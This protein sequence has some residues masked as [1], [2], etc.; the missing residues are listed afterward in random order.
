MVS[1]QQNLNQVGID[2]FLRAL[3]RLGFKKHDISGK[4][5]KIK[6]SNVASYSTHKRHSTPTKYEDEEEN[7]DDEKEIRQPSLKHRIYKDKKTSS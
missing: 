2:E 7:D 3:R 1:N 6:Y 4:R 5:L